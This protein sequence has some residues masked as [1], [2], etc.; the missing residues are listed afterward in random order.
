MPGKWKPADSDF[1]ISESEDPNGI[2]QVL[3]SNLDTT[4]KVG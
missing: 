1:E 4:R 3:K 2:V